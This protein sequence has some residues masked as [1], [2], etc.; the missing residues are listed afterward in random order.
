M[1]QRY[2]NITFQA[3]KI[4]TFTLEECF[5]LGQTSNINKVP[6]TADVPSM[7]TLKMLR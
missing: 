2:I 7:W 6:P 3:T 5:E 1:V 4:P